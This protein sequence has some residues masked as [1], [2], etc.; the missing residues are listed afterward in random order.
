MEDSSPFHFLNFSPKLFLNYNPII[1][2]LENTMQT[3]FEQGGHQK[4][5]RLF[6]F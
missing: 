6:K 4:D 3:F 5:S 1:R 2:H